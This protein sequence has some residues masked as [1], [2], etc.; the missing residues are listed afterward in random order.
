MG[1]IIIGIH[2]LGNKPSKETLKNWWKESML[3]GL[4]NI[5]QDIVLPKFELVYWADILHEQALDETLKDEKHPLYL[6]EKYIEG[7]KEKP[8]VKHPIR[9]KILDWFDQAADKIFLND[10]MTVNYSYITNKLIHNYFKDLEAYYENGE[11]HSNGKIYHARDQIRSRLIE[12]LKKYE[13]DDIFLISHS[14]GTIIAFDVLTF[15]LPELKVQ[16][17]ATMGSPLGIPFVRSKIAQEKKVVLN[18]H[19]K[20]KTPRG[21]KKWYNFSDL[22]DDVAIN[23]SLKDDFDENKSGVKA[24]DFIVHNDY[25]MDN[26]ENHHKSFGYLRT[27]EFSNVLLDFI[28]QKERKFIQKIKDFFTKNEYSDID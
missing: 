9:K 23:Y 2:G 26:E 10:D 28:Q 25:E 12:V 1:K 17:F 3:E 14:M 11:L 13:N 19:N 24:I 8:D 22:E 21:V 27:Q 7:G 6:K 4:K 16:T 15:H 5:G 18:D 20:L